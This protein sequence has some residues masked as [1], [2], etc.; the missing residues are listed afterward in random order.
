MMP[1]RLMPRLLA[2][3]LLL[4][5]GCVER[6][7]PDDERHT[8]MLEGAVQRLEAKI[9]AL[10]QEN[11]RWQGRGAMAAGSGLRVSGSGETVLEQLRRTRTELAIS[12][13]DTSER[14]RA[15]TALHTDLARA[16]DE[17]RSAAERAD[18]LG[19]V[20]DHLI[21]VQQTLNE[22]QRQLDAATTQLADAELGR[23][24]AERAW[25][26]LGAEMLR[27]QPGQTS[28][29]AEVQE[30]VRLIAREL[31]PRA[32]TGGST[33]TTTPAPAPAGH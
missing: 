23:L 17:G 11:R 6:R 25:Y 22:R 21:T 20:R 13:S 15:L 27:V 32:A 24:K 1:G 2:P 9:T 18:A 29:F 16:S 28:E 31:Q 5:A 7:P 3:A 10:E 19:H 26:Q 14:E 8:R 12:R 4:A 30:R 33:P